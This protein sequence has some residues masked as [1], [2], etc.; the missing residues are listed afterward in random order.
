MIRVV[1]SNPRA[2]EILEQAGNRLIDR[3]RVALVTALEIAVLV[4]TVA[5]DRRT[6]QLDEAD[7]TLDQAAADQ[8]LAQEIRVGGY[9]SSTRTA[10]LRRLRLAV[11]VDQFGHRSLH[12]E[13][14]LV[15][16][17]RRLD[18]S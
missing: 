6:K 14:Q 7:P 18:L 4:P 11:N 2:F 5:A 15:I 16:G 8:A 17:D 1:S 9:D 13:G 12:A 10:S 3:P